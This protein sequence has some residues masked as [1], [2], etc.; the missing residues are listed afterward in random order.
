VAFI[1]ALF[2]FSEFNTK[3]A[4]ET[5]VILF[6]RDPKLPEAQKAAE[7]V[8]EEVPRPLARFGSFS[9]PSESKA[10]ALKALSEHPP[11]KDIFSWQHLNYTVPVSAS[12]H[13]HLLDDVSGFVAPGKLTALVGESGAGKASRTVVHLLWYGHHTCGFISRRPSSMSLH[14]EW[15]QALSRAIVLWMGCRFPPISN[16]KREPQ[17][18]ALILWCNPL[19]LA[20]IAS[21]WTLTFRLLLFVKPYFSPPNCVSHPPC[22]LLRK[23][24]SELMYRSPQDLMTFTI[25]IK[26]SINASRCV[27]WKSIAMQWSAL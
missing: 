12:E 2:V 25:Q 26:V 22:L 7:V 5:S 4:G 3:T 8:D 6:K 23:K 18:I 13:K 11:M 14:N 10:N 17:Q 16:L 15:Q 1:I 24:L 9:T 20:A 21:R 19:Y 27:V